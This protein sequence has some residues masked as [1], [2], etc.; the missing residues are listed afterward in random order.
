MVRPFA[1]P[2]APSGIDWPENKVSLWQPQQTARH[3]MPYGSQAD[4]H[5]ASKAAVLP[6][7][8]RQYLLRLHTT[9]WL[10]QEPAGPCQH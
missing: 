2:G 8:D 7:A 3:T 10:G 6:T 4:S 9:K 5:P 1:G